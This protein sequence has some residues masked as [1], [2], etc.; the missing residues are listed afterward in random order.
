MNLVR[1]HFRNHIK[2]YHYHRLINLRDPI[3]RL[4][5]K[6]FI[7]AAKFRFEKNDWKEFNSDDLAIIE[8]ERKKRR[9]QG[10]VIDTTKH[11][12][13][14]ICPACVKPNSTNVNFCTGCS[15][16]LTEDDVQ[17]LPDNVFLDIITGKN[18]DT[19][20]LFRN[21]SIM[22]FNDKFGVSVPN[23]HIDVIPIEVFEDV[24]SLGKEHVAMLEAL[25]DAGIEE[26][27]KRDLSRFG[28]TDV[29]AE[30]RKNVIAG[31]NFPVSVKHL[32]LHMVLPPC[33]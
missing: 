12:Y 15:F 6:K 9:E 27:K 24:T 23:D 16:P 18:K 5:H 26:F 13:G 20:V 31:Y 22:L 19:P 8:E 3:L 21:E 4:Y 7:M 1:V 30:L 14:K 25:F 28:W 32:H 10:L 33:K 29:D 11:T 17:Q 2:K